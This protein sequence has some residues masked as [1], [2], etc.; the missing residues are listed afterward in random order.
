VTTKSRGT[1]PSGT[2]RSSGGAGGSKNGSSPTRRIS[3]AA[4]A[5]RAREEF[6]ELTQTPVE[7]VT[8]V[9]RTDN[10]WLVT[11]EGLELRRIP[12]TMDV[13]GIYQVELNARGQIAGW[14]RVTRLSRSQVEEG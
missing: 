2:A 4:A 1:A 12:E 9:Q 7:R 8:A 5:R 14:N 6:T 13:L 10:G 11:L 3:A